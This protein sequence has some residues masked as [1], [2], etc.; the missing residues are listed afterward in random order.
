MLSCKFIFRDAIF[1]RTTSMAA[2]VD[3]KAQKIDGKAKG[4]FWKSNLPMPFKT[5]L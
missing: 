3:R 2:K 5:F 1:N 4:Y